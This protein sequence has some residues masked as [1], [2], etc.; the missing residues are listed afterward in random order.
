MY[1]VSGA[2]L[3]LLLH[4]DWPN[5]VPSPSHRSPTTA[6]F[7]SGE[8]E[9]TV[10]VLVPI[11][12]ELEQP[13]VQSNPPEDSANNSTQFEDADAKPLAAPPSSLP[14]TSISVLGAFVTGYLTFVK[15]TGAPLACPAGKVAA[16][17][18][19]IFSSWASI[20]PVPLSI[21][22]FAAY[23][24]MFYLSRQERWWED[25]RLWWLAFGMST[26]SFGLMML[27]LFVIKAQCVYCVASATFAACMLL[28]A[29]TGR[30]YG[31]AESSRRWVL[32]A[33]GATLLGAGAVLAK[34]QKK[35]SQE[36]FLELSFRYKPEHPP[37][38][39]E[40]NQAAI[41]LAQHL[42][43]IGAMCY[44]A[45]WCPHCQVQRETFGRQAVEFAPL[46]QCYDSSEKKLEMCKGKADSFPTWFINDKKYSG[47]QELYEL[48]EYSGFT[49]Y[50]KE[51]YVKRTDADLVYIWGAD[52]D[53]E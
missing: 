31:K 48:A 40:S 23:L 2:A 14:L 9:A 25:S 3:A 6:R 8:S 19:V 33:A 12:D 4:V 10:T 17:S 21:F 30:A 34:E 1:C 49:K 5:F 7:S 41:E 44:T 26:F 15:L 45:W 29:E 13:I 35:P 16:C 51:A 37:V 18:K 32:G 39:S 36:S 38:R 11:D 24:T 52:E 53:D 27:L 28:L 47:D 46:V 20:G 50:P 42:T 22:G 43:K